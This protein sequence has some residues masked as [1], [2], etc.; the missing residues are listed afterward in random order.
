MQDS[1]R[2]VHEYDIVNILRVNYLIVFLACTVGICENVPSEIGNTAGNS[3]GET[4]M[5]NIVVR[6]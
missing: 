3:S 6:F 1:F 5:Q 2:S 4:E